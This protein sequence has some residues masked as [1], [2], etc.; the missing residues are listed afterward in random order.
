MCLCFLPEVLPTTGT[1]DG[2]FSLAS[3]DT[4]HLMALGAVEIAMLAVLQPVEELEEL[5]ILLIPLVGIA[6]Q[7]A[8]N[9]PDHHAIAD[10]EQD[11]IHLRGYADHGQK[12]CY[13]ARAQ[14]HHIQPVWSIAPR[15]EAAQKRGQ[16]CGELP[17]PTTDSVHK[18]SPLGCNLL[19]YIILQNLLIATVE[20]E[21]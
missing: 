3:G 16:F 2:D 10:D 15:H 20:A 21:N 13:Q 18:Q 11:H 17:K 6:G 19:S 8:P 4:H 14:D 12:A 5:P 9:R 1:G 7:A